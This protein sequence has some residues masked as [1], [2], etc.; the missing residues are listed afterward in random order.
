[1]N[2]SSPHFYREKASELGR[3]TATV[4]RALELD[5]EIRAAGAQPVFTLRH[6]AELTGASWPYLR[7]IVAR[8]R[9]PYLDINR[10][11]GDGRTRS[12]S[13]PE[14]VLMD[15]QRWILHNILCACRVHPSSYAYQAGRSILDCAKAH[16]GARWL[17]KL[18]IH[19]F[20]DSVPERRIY[21]TFRKIGYPRLLSMELSRLCTREGHSKTG[22]SWEDIE[23]YRDAPYPLGLEGR[24]PQGAPTSGLLAN[25]AMFDADTQLD[26]LARSHDLV[27]TRYS[28]DLTFSAGAGFTRQRA[29]QLVREVAGIVE[30]SGFVLHRA[31]TR[32][33]S[34][35]ARHIVLGL[36][37]AEDQVRLLPEFKRRLEV[38]VRGVTK[39]GLT[40]HAR[41]RHFESV[42][43]M[44]NHID[45]CIAFADCIDVEFAAK[46]RDAWNSA[47]NDQGYV[48]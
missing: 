37:L 27:Y 16:L 6:L 13:S 1:V 4:G 5:R 21:P 29:A 32:V 33:V 36:L 20:F 12:I 48:V 26:G 45:G 35:G 8:R 11:K 46:M 24:L 9:D 15:V 18:D 10:P 42:L 41:W 39:F 14:P 2:A 43:S 25:V 30:R 34:P 17:V 47:L 23:R 38:H 19:D 44:I 3:D 22:R 40:E 28:D 7:E 31:K